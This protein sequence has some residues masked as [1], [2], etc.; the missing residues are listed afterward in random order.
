M[1]PQRC[2]RPHPQ[3]LREQSQGSLKVEEWGGRVRITVTQCEKDANG[4]CGLNDGGRS[5]GAKQC[6]W[7]KILEEARRL[8][9]P[10]LPEGTQP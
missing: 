1:V 9:L 3:N 7:L 2:P 8:T 10:E 6:R 4:Q 5:L